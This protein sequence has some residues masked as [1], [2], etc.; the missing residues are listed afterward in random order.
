[1]SNRLTLAKVDEL[2]KT[3]GR[4]HKQALKD[5]EK[6]LQK[7][8]KNVVL[9]IWK[10]NL[11]WKSPKQKDEAWDVCMGLCKREPPITDLE[12]VARIHEF[13]GLVLSRQNSSINSAGKEVQSMWQK[14]AKAAGKNQSNVF[15]SMFQTSVKLDLWSDAQLAMLNLRNLNRDEPKYYF[16]YIAVSQLAADNVRDVDPKAAETD[17]KWAFAFLSKAVEQTLSNPSARNAVGSLNELRL[18]AQIYRKQGKRKE[19][20][21]ILDNK[22]IGITSKVGK[23]D[24]EFTKAKVEL[25]EE[26]EMYADLYKFCYDILKAG[27]NAP[28]G[29]VETSDWSMWSHL[30]Q[31]AAELPGKKDGKEVEELIQEYMAREPSQKERNIWMAYLSS[32]RIPK[33]APRV[34][35][36]R[37]KKYFD[38][39]FELHCCFTDLRHLVISLEL[40]ERGSFVEYTISS[41]NA[42]PEP[43][44]KADQLK[45][46]MKKLNSLKFEY[47]LRAAKGDKQTL[48]A[49]VR[50]CLDLYKKRYELDVD[51]SGPIAGDEAAVL[52]IMCLV[53][54]HDLTTSKDVISAEKYY[55]QAA[56]LCRPLIEKSPADRQVRLFAVKL[57]MLL[58][59]GSMASEQYLF[60]RIKEI[61]QDTLSHTLFSRLSITHP[62]PST[63]PASMRLEKPFRDSCTMLQQA[64]TIYERS[65]SKIR[66]FMGQALPTFQ[67]DKALEFNDMIIRLSTSYTV[68]LL[69]VEFG[70]ICRLR[71]QEQSALNYGSVD[72]DDWLSKLSDNRDDGITYDFEPPDLTPFASRIRNGPVPN[73]RS[74][75]SA[76]RTPQT[77]PSR[78]SRP[79]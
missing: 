78:P 68:R 27:L 42:A 65:I 40:D 30:M 72:F 47:L 79:S 6:K 61:M 58:G 24:P 9:Q 36:E 63:T 12:I 56:A 34:D 25:M 1:M 3:Y 33:D 50:K 31:S 52:A 19:L 18:V 64:L 62:F 15:I 69:L 37:C 13:A 54:L 76:P 35:I 59:L 70:R 26:E 73:P 49:F 66:G 41:T 67:F 46:I 5:C 45:W 60:C 17:S 28:D 14:A 11:L 4:N 43:E 29:S 22:D 57:Y 21:S 7:D 51:A 16:G 20:L 71:G 74:T 23:N 38:H 77:R 32:S 53:K 44:D 39:F 8:P 2:D 48:E 10:A 75:S 55:I